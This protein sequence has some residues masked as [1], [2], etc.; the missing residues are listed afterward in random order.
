MR[1]GH[2]LGIVAPCGIWSP[3]SQERGGQLF[4]LVG[5]I[6][7]VAELSQVGSALPL[8]FHAQQLTKT[9]YMEWSCRFWEGDGIVGEGHGV[10]TA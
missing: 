6:G 5:Y 8:P 9:P 7:N 1:E 10:V 4:G 2:G 3:A